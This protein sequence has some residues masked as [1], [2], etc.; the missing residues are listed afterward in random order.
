MSNTLWNAVRLF[1]SF[2]VFIWAT[3]SS[4]DLPTGIKSNLLIQLPKD[5]NNLSEGYEY[6]TQSNVTV[7]LRLLAP[8]GCIL[9]SE[10]VTQN[11]ISGSLTVVMG[12]VVGVGGSNEFN[13]CFRDNRFKCQR[14]TDPSKFQQLIIKQYRLLSIV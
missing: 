5:I 2:F 4:A 11:I 9:A 14:K 8:N 3:F 12:K 13:I 1:L 6:P 7:T 10:A